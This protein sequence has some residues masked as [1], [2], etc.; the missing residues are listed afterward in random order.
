MKFAINLYLVN[1]QKKEHA[2]NV[3]HRRVKLQGR[4][5]WTNMVQAADKGLEYH[6]DTHR[7]KNV[8]EC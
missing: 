3:H 8:S 5:R 6:R 4:F 1:L 2:N 7:L